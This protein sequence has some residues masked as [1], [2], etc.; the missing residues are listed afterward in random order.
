MPEVSVEKEPVEAVQSDEP[1]SAVLI[2]GMKP[3]E[4]DE[5]LVLTDV[6]Q[7]LPAVL[8]RLFPGPCRVLESGCYPK[9]QCRHIPP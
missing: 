7:V 3:P 9:K 6:R 8:L 1:T 4:R 5:L 2:V